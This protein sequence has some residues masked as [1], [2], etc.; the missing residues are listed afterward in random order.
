MSGPLVGEQ[1]IASRSREATLADYLAN[2][3]SP[4]EASKIL[5]DVYYREYNFSEQLNRFAEVE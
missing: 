1:L 3:K 5:S 2:G 4:L